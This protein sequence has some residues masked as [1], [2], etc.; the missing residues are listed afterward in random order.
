MT[1]GLDFSRRVLLALRAGNADTFTLAERFGA[2]YSQALT[3]LRRKGFVIDLPSGEVSMTPLGREH[4]P[5]RRP[6]KVVS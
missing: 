2:N 4:C 6:K 5:S 3:A 1:I